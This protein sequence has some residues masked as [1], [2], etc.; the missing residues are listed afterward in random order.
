VSRSRE[1]MVVGR[2]AV[3]IGCV[4]VGAAAGCSSWSRAGTPDT[5]AS[6]STVAQRPAMSAIHDKLI[7]GIGATRAYW[8]DTHTPNATNINGSDYG[9]DPSLP[10]YLTNNGAVYR[11]VGDL[12]TGRIQAYTLAM[13]T[14]DAR[15]VLRQLRQEL[16]SD[17]TVAWDLTRDQCYRVAF[18]SPTLQAAGRSM[19]EAQLQYIQEDGT[20][21]TSPDRFNIASIWLED[22]G[23]PPDPEKGC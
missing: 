7:P 8:D 1:M 14:V 13:H 5:L 21:A 12:G 17:A 16:P 3:G 10:E 23:S 19:A 15:E 4:L 20:T 18:N 9:D 22:A 6:A 2:M 11:D